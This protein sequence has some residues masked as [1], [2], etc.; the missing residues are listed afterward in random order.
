MPFGQVPLN[1]QIRGAD[2]RIDQTQHALAGQAARRAARTRDG[3]EMNRTERR[4]GV[5]FKGGGRLIAL[6]GVKGA[7]WNPDPRC[8]Q[9]P[10]ALLKAP[11]DHGHC[12]LES[13]RIFTSSKQ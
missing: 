6:D 1:V 7:G 3:S 13:H 4:E 9:G 8:D 5:A 10:L 2:L 11:Y 12:S